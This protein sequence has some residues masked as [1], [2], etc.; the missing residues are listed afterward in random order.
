MRNI[1]FNKPYNFGKEM[2]YIKNVIAGGKTSGDGEYTSKCQSILEHQL[3][4]HNILMTTS[5]T[6]ALE[7]ALQLIPLQ[8]G[9]E[10]IMPSYTFPSTANSVLLQKGCVVF[11]EV[12]H[13]DLCIDVN[14]IQ[15]KITEKTKVIMVVHYGGNACDMDAIM[16]IARKYDLY[17][18]EDAAQGFLSTY[19]RQALGTIG[20]FGC[21]SFHETKNISAGEGG[22]LAINTLNPDVVKRAEYIRQKGTNRKDYCLGNV[23]FYQWVDVGSS[24]CPSEILMAYLY[25]QLEQIEEIHEK[26]VTIFNHY[27]KLLEKIDSNKIMYYATG[28]SFGGF[29]AHIFYMIFNKPSYAIYFM[30]RLKEK[31]IA[32]YTHFIP[33]HVSKMGQSLGYHV[34]DFPYER[35]LYKKLVRLPLYPS[36]TED[37]LQ[38]VMM[39]IS[40]VLK[41]LDHREDIPDDINRYSCI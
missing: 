37:V 11:T 28:N 24:Y 19:G 8:E 14:R 12:N 22:A 16:A 17:V 1:P 7:L 31:G 3:D 41:E 30:E 13:D 38:Q 20:H 10:V 27:Q 21:Y 40:E 33:L 26:R 36:M 32:A 18:I 39:A 5:C 4:A 29:N 35:D 23:E 25:A 2:D 34:D 9:D 6:H 15:E